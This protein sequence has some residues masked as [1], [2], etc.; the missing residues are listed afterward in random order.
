MNAWLSLWLAVVLGGAPPHDLHA[1]YGNLG[2]EGTTAVLQIR[3][4]Q[5]DLEEA[6]GKLGGKEV[7]LLEAT[8]EID[9]L[10]LRYLAANFILEVEGSPLKGRILGSGSDELDREPVWWYQIRFDAPSPIQGARITNTIL[11]ELFEDQSNILRVARFPEGSRKAYYFAAG[12]ET[13][14]IRF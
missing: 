3:I 8:P 6:L 12:E 1:S 4:F 10:F 2:I 7:S 5:D 14:E 9:A 13:V 11:F